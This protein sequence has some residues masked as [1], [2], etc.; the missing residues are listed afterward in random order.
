MLL[1]VYGICGQEERLWYLMVM[2]KEFIQLHSHRMGQYNLTLRR[3][4]LIIP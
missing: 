1:A 3:A 4:S 2:F